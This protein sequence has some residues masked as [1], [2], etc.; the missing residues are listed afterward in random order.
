MCLDGI[1]F[2]GTMSLRKQEDGAS[3]VKDMKRLALQKGRWLFHR[4]RR[5]RGQD[6]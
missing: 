5:E 2:D 1:E 6:W 4:D 3:R